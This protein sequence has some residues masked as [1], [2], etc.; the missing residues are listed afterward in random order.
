MNEKRKKKELHNQIKTLVKGAG[1][2][3]VVVNEITE[4]IC[5][6][7]KNGTWANMLSR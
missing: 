3:G 5:P 1:T 4:V 2:L 6:N 7:T